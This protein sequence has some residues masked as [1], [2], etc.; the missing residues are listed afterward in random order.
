MVKRPLGSQGPEITSVGIGT[1]AMGGPWEFGWGPADD[2]Q[3]VAAIRHAVTSGI[4][5][6]DTAAVYGIGHAEE[7]VGRALEPFAVGEDV[8]VFTKCGR[9]RAE[10]GS[11]ISFD[12]RPESI[13]AE[14]EQSLRRLGIERIDLY[15]FH[16]PDYGTGTPVEESWGVMQELVREGKVRWVGR[17]QFPGRAARA[18]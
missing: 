8:L 3:S 12:L 4:N 16:W 13:R 10:D 7:V 14:C 18:L 2:E 11:G 1:W 5:W 15:Q 17:L 9:K 6:I